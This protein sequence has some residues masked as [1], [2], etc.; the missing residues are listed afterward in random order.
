[1]SEEFKKGAKTMFDYILMATANHY[2]MNPTINKQCAAEAA[3]ATDLAADALR[4]VSPELY[5][6]WLS[7][8]ELQ[9]INAELRK[10]LM[11]AQKENL[12]LNT[13][14]NT[15]FGEIIRKLDA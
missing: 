4:E 12:R 10:D 9:K 15:T 2:H 11:Q 3:Y 5:G 8:V 6:E 7:L 14:L 13:M 1:M